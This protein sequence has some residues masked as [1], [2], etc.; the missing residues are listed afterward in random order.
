MLENASGSADK[1][2]TAIKNAW[3]RAGL[4]ADTGEA[5][6]FAPIKAF[7]ET[8]KFELSTFKFYENGEMFFDISSFDDEFTEFLVTAQ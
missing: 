4:S 2:L 6:L 3:F 5:F 1:A 7:D 8:K